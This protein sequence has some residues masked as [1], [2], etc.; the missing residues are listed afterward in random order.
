LRNCFPDSDFRRPSKCADGFPRLQH[1]TANGA[2]QLDHLVAIAARR[3][4]IFMLSALISGLVAT[5]WAQ[6]GSD[7]AALHLREGNGLYLDL[8]AGGAG[9]RLTCM[10]KRLAAISGARP[11]EA[12][13]RFPEIFGGTFL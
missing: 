12:L 4:K 5:A 13:L 2:A 10:E 3:E 11:P 8:E 6:S 1:H 7:I 9:I